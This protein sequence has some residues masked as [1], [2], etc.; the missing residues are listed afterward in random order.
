MAVG[1]ILRP[2]IRQ[3][4]RQIYRALNV[5]DELVK[6]AW[7]TSPTRNIVGR[8]GVLGARHGAAGG[9][10]ASAFITDLD[11]D[12]LDAVPSFIQPSPSRR[13]Y[14]KGSGIRRRTSRRY[15]KRKCYPKYNKRYRMG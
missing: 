10:V 7:M 9:L 4:A 6:T 13:Q 12:D 14:Q 2:F 1:V 8:G 15:D 3:A 5:Q 11:D